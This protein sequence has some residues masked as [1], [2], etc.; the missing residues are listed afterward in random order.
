MRS[1]ELSKSTAKIKKSLQ[2]QVKL[3]QI[4][5]KIMVVKPKKITTI[6]KKY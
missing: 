3:F 4:S 6:L 2:I 1:T 5:S